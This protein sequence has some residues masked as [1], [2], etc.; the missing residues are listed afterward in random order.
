MCVQGIFTELA[1]EF[2]LSATHTR[3][4]F[5]CFVTV[6]RT[7]AIRVKRQGKAPAYYNKITHRLM[8]IGI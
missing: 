4:T 2:A 6:E 5:N 7:K 1:E 3:P 8:Q